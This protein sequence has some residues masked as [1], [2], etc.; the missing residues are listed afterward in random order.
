MDVRGPWI[1]EGDFTPRFALDLAL[2]DVRLGL[3]MARAW[4]L[5]MKAMEAALVY[6]TQGSA[7]GYGTEDCNAVYK[8]IGK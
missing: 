1:A 4:D 3:E 2:K 5:D 7:S 8:V 6:Y